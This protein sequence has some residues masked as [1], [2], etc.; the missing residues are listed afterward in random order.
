MTTTKSFDERNRDTQDNFERHAFS[1]LTYVDGAGSVVKVR[2]TGTVDEDVPV[3]NSG[4]GFNIPKDF[5]TECFLHSDGSD[6]AG[7]FAV[8][9]L[10]RN[11][12]RR[13][14]ENTGGV[15]NPLDPDKAVEFNEKRTHATESNFAVG[16]GLFEVIGN[17]IYIR[18]DLHVEG[19]LYVGGD[20]QAGGNISTAG[21]FIGPDPS[22]R[23]EPPDAIPGFDA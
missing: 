8:M 7:K 15:Q 2:G 23:G 11:K 1:E 6:A 3:I 12:Q 21:R 10:P 4:Y 19:N 18:G 16:E 22:G 9:T 14:R 17:K 20:I 13:W 5:N